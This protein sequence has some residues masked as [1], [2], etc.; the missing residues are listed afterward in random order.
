M[1]EFTTKEQEELEKYLNS[2]HNLDYVLLRIQDEF[3]SQVAGGDI[4]ILVKNISTA[5]KI[6]LDQGFSKQKTP[7]SLSIAKMMGKGVRQPFKAAALIKNDPKSVIKKSL[8][9]ERAD[10]SSLNQLEEKKLYKK[11]IILHLTDHLAHKSTMNNSKVRLHPDIEESFWKHSKKTK[12][13][14]KVPDKPEKIIHKICRGVFDYEGS[15]PD[16]YK[17]ECKNL[18]NNLT[19]SQTERFENH[20]K[21]V[22]FKASDLVVRKVE[23]GEFDSLRNDLEKYAQY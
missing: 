21:K 12:Q 20:C 8:Y 16:Y 7:L 19:P 4:D 9:R 1:T 13:N 6:A 23:A 22:F 2:I 14:F 3:P 15:F 17:E 18:S 11:N 10:Y 5:E